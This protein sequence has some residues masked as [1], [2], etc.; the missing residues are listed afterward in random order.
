MCGICMRFML[1]TRE[2]QN[3]FLRVEDYKDYILREMVSDIANYIIDHLS[4]QK[5]T[6]GI[7]SNKGIGAA[8]PIP[9]E[10]IVIDA[11]LHCNI[12]SSYCI[13]FENSNCKINS[14]RIRVDRQVS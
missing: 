5:I 3:A 4:P 13:D 1:H 8:A 10:E 12:S 2:G 6:I 14:I 7:V 11:K 9:V